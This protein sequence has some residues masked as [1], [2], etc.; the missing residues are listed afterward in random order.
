MSLEKFDNPEID[1]VTMGFDVAK[2][3]YSNGVKRMFA[4]TKT[5]DQ[6]TEDFHECE[7][8]LFDERRNGW[9]LS[10]GG[11]IANNG[12]EYIIAVFVPMELGAD[13]EM[14]LVPGTPGAEGNRETIL[15]LSFSNTSMYPLLHRSVLEDGQF[16]T[17]QTFQGIPMLTEHAPGYWLFHGAKVFHELTRARAIAEKYHKTEEKSA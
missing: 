6:I 15:G 2:L 16:G 14:G 3:R 10:V 4:L 1:L 9:E 7:V 17:V 12:D 11:R 13:N 8:D 5:P